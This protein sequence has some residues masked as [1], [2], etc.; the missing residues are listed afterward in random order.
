MDVKSESEDDDVDYNDNGDDDDDAD[1]DLTAAAEDTSSNMDL[2][3]TE[4]HQPGTPG[5]LHTV[6][7]F[8]P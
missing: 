5:V 2:S 6:S 3:G 7:T 1:D 8:Q 4:D